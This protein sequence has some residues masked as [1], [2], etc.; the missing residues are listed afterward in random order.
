MKPPL[1]LDSGKV[2]FWAWSGDKPFG[3]MPTGDNTSIEIYGFAICIL[4]GKL[5]RFSCDR[6]WEVQNDMDFDSIEEAKVS[7][8]PQYS[9][10]PIQWNKYDDADIDA[11]I[12][13]NQRVHFYQ[14]VGSRRVIQKIFDHLQKHKCYWMMVQSIA[15]DVWL[16][17]IL[18]KDTQIASEISKSNMEDKLDTQKK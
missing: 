6:N 9:N 4:D 10:Q 17:S 1:H 15:N 5:Y 7:S 13:D 18:K 14:E 12:S 16:L 2:L 3:K 8:Y 11:L